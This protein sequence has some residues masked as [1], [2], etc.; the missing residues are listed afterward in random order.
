[1]N[2]NKQILSN[3][4]NNHIL[5]ESHAHYWT[6]QHETGHSDF[7]SHNDFNY[8]PYVYWISSHHIFLS[9]WFLSIFLNGNN[10]DSKLKFCKM[11]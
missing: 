8:D 9:K 7:E 5:L 1:M 11:N 6:E 2:S 10:D 4:Y 3:V